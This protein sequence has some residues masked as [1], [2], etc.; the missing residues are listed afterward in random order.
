MMMIMQNTNRLI[1]DFKD[2]SADTIWKF[3]NAM[4]VNY[5]VYSTHLKGLSPF[6]TDN[7]VYLYCNDTNVVIVCLD[8][9]GNDDE[10]VYP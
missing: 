5:T 3:M 7:D 2:Q 9:C 8:R 6:L 1:N 10:Q 4:A